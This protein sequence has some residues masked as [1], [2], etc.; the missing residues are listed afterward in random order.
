MKQTAPGKEMNTSF[1]HC[2][3]GFQWPHEKM[4]ADFGLPDQDRARPAL[5]ERA[6]KRTS[7]PLGFTVT[8]VKIE[9]LGADATPQAA[10]AARARGLESGSCKRA[11]GHL[12]RRGPV[13]ARPIL[14][15][16]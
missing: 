1:L 16:T 3:L 7:R 12:S 15:R 14:T 5:P 10:G 4:H 11:A 6:T 2:S 8:L 13:K 9:R